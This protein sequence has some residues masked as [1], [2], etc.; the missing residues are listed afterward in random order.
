M[1]TV[2]RTTVPKQTFDTS[3]SMLIIGKGESEFKNRD[4][5]KAESIES[6]EYMYGATSELSIAYKEALKAGTNNIFLC[7]CYKF[8]DY[9]EIAELINKEEFGYITPLFNF[10]ETFST[11]DGKIMYLCEFYSNMFSDKITQL[12]FTDKHASLYEDINHF[13]NDMNN[14]TRLF[15]E[16]AFL[17]LE[18]GDNMCF[19]MNV[20][21]DYKF[22]NVVLAS[23][24]MQSD[25]RYYP[26]KNVGQVVFDINN[27]DVYGN[28]C[29]YFAYDEVAKSTIENFLNFRRNNDP[30][31]FVPINLIIQKIKRALDFS[32]YSG[33]LF[34]P[35]MKISLENKVNAIMSKF[36]GTLIEKFNL[37]NIG[38]IQNDDY[39]ITVIIS[40]TIKPYNSM[41]ELDLRME[42]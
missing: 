3:D 31:K 9:I 17:K 1:I 25:L 33:V 42:V 10:S 29:V 32:S 7:N 6:V 18:F 8:T 15:K 20:L 34:S 5:V 41:E 30:E 4:I 14:K 16:E 27:F 2:N 28:E 39:T 24:L 13:L 12:I 26:K 38:F 21:K 37:I 19:V 23:I 11:D 40:L 22:A 35:Y 36:V